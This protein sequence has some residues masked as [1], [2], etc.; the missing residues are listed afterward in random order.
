MTDLWQACKRAK[1]LALGFGGAYGAPS[2]RIERLSKLVDSFLYTF[3]NLEDI[4]KRQNAFVE[5]ISTFTQ[6]FDECTDFVYDYD[7]LKRNAKKFDKR[8]PAS[9]RVQLQYQLPRYVYTDEDIIKFEDRL[10]FQLY[11]MDV[12]LDDIIL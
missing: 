1:P 9:D 7:D 12:K 8:E 4:S 10:R 11:A 3:E 2:E 5:R 6:T